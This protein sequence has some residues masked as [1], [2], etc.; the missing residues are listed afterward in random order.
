VTNS[1]DDFNRILDIKGIKSFI[2]KLDP[3]VVK[4]RLCMGFLSKK[5]KNNITRYQKRFFVLLS[6]K[7]L[8]DCLKDD[9]ILKDED[10]PPWLEL[11]TIYYFQCKSIDDSSP[12]IGKISLRNCLSITVEDNQHKNILENLKQD[13][14]DFSSNLCIM[15]GLFSW[16]TKLGLT[17]PE[18]GFGFKLTTKERTYYF[19]ADLITEM[20]K[21]IIAIGQSLKNYKDLHP[22]FIQ[23]DIAVNDVSPG[24][25][26]NLKNNSCEFLEGSDFPPLINMEKIEN[27]NEL[28][29]KPIVFAK[30][31]YL[32]KKAI[33]KL[34]KL[35]GWEQRYLCLKD[36]KLFWV[37]N[38]IQKNEP[39][40]LL[41]VKNIENCDS[42]KENQFLLVFL[43]F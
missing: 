31:G 4:S 35:I 1:L 37:K 41:Q 21:W 12:F 33:N 3:K 30:E 28:Q 38:N 7:S 18:H 23:D 16:E 19:Y 40:T 20:N 13:F 27:A 32:F 36:E 6:A 43:L 42:H 9:I 15:K 24:K 2:D 39:K 34:S 29:N 11:E 25:H 17:K 14:L 22:N 8:S 26:F 5:G 10:L